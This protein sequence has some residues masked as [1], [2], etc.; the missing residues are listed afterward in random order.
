[1]TVKLGGT[2]WVFLNSSRT[3]TDLLEKRAAIYCSR[4]PFPM[5]QDIVSRGGRIVL[6][7]YNNDWRQLRRIMHQILSTRQTSTYRGYQDLESKQLLW[8]YLHFPDKWYLHNGRYSNSVIMS[9]VFGRR[10]SWDDPELAALFETAEEFLALQQAGVNIVDGFPILAKLPEFLQWWR[11]RGERI[12]EK[13]VGVYRRVFETLEKKIEEGTQRD[14][15][16][17]Q[18]LKIAETENFTE[19][20][21]LFAAGS[22]LE[23][24]SD[25]TRVSLGQMIAGAATYPDWV[26]RVRKQLDEVCGANAERLPEWSD[27]DKLP[28]INAVV[29][30]SFRWRPN[31]APL[32][33]PTSLIKDDEYEGY[34]FPAGT[35][36]TWNAW[37]ILSYFE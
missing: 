16:A 12:H 11:P 2:N 22:L 31:I 32:G 7:P 14:C 34:K 28:Y 13:T 19:N 5:T 30:E 9:V 10:A 24:G 18:M 21:K 25:T 36:F 26:E 23:A 1:M 27:Y 6:M 4:P 37:Y 35:V 8:D 20:Q 3:V 15:F 17:L 33:A 29:K